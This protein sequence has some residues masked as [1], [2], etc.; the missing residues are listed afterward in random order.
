MEKEEFNLHY[1]RIK[2]KYE[3]IVSK[4]KA[5]DLENI[6]IHEVGGTLI[7]QTEGAKELYKT[8]N[9]DKAF[10]DE[11][12]ENVNSTLEKLLYLEPIIEINN[13]TKSGLKTKNPTNL[14]QLI[15]KEQNYLKNKYDINLKISGKKDIVSYINPSAIYAFIS[16][17]IG[18]SAKWTPKD[19]KIDILLDKNDSY[20]IIKIE[21]KFEN[22]PVRTEIG[23]G[24][25]IGSKYT[26]LF[27]DAIGGKIIESKNNNVYSKEFYLPI[28]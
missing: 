5:S 15:E 25:K 3:K 26:K 18:D 23:M 27:L 9:I 1:E 20:I 6:F 22:E 7:N 17:N 8:K 14:Y 10:Y 24:Q 21:N 4:G 19:E 28:I 11:I 12:M 16:T 2:E 13:F